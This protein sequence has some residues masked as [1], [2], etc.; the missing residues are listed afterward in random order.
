MG[1]FFSS[2][3]PA[4]S[5]VGTGSSLARSLDRNSRGRITPRELK[6]VEK[7]LKEEVGH[8]DTERIMEGLRPNM[9]SDGQLGGKNISARESSDALDYM[10]K[11][12]HGG[13]STKD[14]DTARKILD[15]YQ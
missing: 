13:V 9:D 2:K 8:H 12:H 4:V 7:R 11:G 15:E 10:E 14:I 5:S 3:K 6:F 1:L